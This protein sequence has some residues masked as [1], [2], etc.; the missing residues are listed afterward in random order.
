MP[1]FA[2]GN[3]V[4]HLLEKFVRVVAGIEDA[5][6]LA[7]QFI[8]RILTDGAELVVDVS[9]GALDVGYCHDGVLVQGEFLVRQFF[10]RSRASGQVF[11]RG[12]FRGPPFG[13]LR[14]QSCGALLHA[15]FQ[16]GVQDANLC[17]CKHA[18]VNFAVDGDSGYRQQS[19]PNKNAYDDDETRQPPSRLRALGALTQQPHLFGSHLFRGCAYGIHKSFRFRDVASGGSYVCLLLLGHHAL[20]EIERGMDLGIK[21]LQS[22]LLIGVVHRQKAQRTL[23]LGDGTLCDLIVREHGPLPGQGKRPR[24]GFH[25]NHMFRRLLDPIHHGIAVGH[26]V[27]IVRRQ[28]GIPPGR[29]TQEDCQQ[30]SHHETDRDLAPE[31]ALDRCARPLVLG[32]FLFQ[33]EVL[34]LQV[35]PATQRNYLRNQRYEHR[36][37]NQRNHCRDRLDH[38]SEQIAAMPDVPDFHQVGGATRQDEDPKHPEN[39]VEWNLSILVNEINEDHWNAV[40]RQRDQSIG[41]DVEPHHSRVPQVADSV[42]HEVRGK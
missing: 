25:L 2:L 38:P 36:R 41:D 9:D 16:L 15:L 31:G 12:R 20:G 22:P 42:R 37:C 14:L 11:F 10:E 5:V 23:V 19:R 34:F 35:H 39:A 24:A 30:H 6:I 13:N 1:D 3:G 17:P 26:P 8:F 4:V 40:I 27:G 32:N 21:R 28:P 33:F 18:G 7:D 29:K